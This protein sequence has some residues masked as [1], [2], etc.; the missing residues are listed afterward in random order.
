MSE[1]V[2]AHPVSPWRPIRFFLLPVGGKGTLR[3]GSR[4]RRRINENNDLLSDRCHKAHPGTV[5]LRIERI[6]DKGHSSIYVI[7]RPKALRFI[8]PASVKGSRP[9]L[10]AENRDS[11]AD[12]EAP[13]TR[14]AYPKS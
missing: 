12:Q 9:A 3:P 14:C 1:E 11:P 5:T 13:E 6:A 10:R 2:I 8:L 7:G 4:S